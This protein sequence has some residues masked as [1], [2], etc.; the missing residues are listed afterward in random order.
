VSDCR[1]LSTG[2]QLKSC[3]LSYRPDK[4]LEHILQ[5]LKKTDWIG[6]RPLCPPIYERMSWIISVT[7][8]FLWA[9]RSTNICQKKTHFCSCNNSRQRIITEPAR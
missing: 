1:G 3:F 2:K 5:W 7:W 6:C 9:N 8:C 4:E